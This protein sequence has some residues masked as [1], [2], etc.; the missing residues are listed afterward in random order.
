M[1]LNLRTYD[2]LNYGFSIDRD[3]NVSINLRTTV[4]L[5]VNACGWVTAN[6]LI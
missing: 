1:P 3:L 4:S 5:T 6:D 2:C